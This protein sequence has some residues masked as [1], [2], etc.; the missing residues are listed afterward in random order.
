MNGLTMDTAGTQSS[1]DRASHQRTIPRHFFS[2][3]SIADRTPGDLT[4]LFDSKYML[5]C[6]SSGEPHAEQSPSCCL[7]AAEVASL[8]SVPCASKPLL[9]HGV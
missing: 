4:H 1:N 6:A 3:P 8:C 7:S 5:P 9:R 2:T